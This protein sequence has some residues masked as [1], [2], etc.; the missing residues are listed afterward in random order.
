VGLEFTAAE[1]RAVALDTAVSPP[2]VTRQARV[3]LPPGALAPALNGANLADRAAVTAAVRQA[4]EAVGRPRRIAVA[5]PDV[6]ARLSLVKLDTVPASLAERDQVLQWHVRK[7]APFPVEQAQVAIAAGRALPDGA[8]EF[9]VALARRDVVEEYE[10]VCAAA[11]AHAGV[12][13]VATS[14]L[15][16]VASRALAGAAGDWMLVHLAGDYASI[17]IVRDGLPIFFRLRGSEAEGSLADAVHQA[18]M[19]FEDRL[20]GQ[21]FSRVVVVGAGAEAGGEALALALPPRLQTGVER[22]DL[23]TVLRFPDRIDVPADTA[24]ALAPAAGLVLREA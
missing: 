7:A 9:L 14:A 22:L 1:V 19:Y 15:V 23:A 6:V 4:L 24:A 17:A 8:H 5:L 12:V 11:A 10:S 3:A 16:H 21:A 20:A 13:D 18:A 2:A